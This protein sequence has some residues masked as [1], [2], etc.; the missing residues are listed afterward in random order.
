MGTGCATL[1]GMKRWSTVALVFGL[2]VVVPA[3][4]RARDG[5]GAVAARMRNVVFHLDNGVELRVAD[6]SGHLVSR[7]KNKPP[8]FDDVK[9]YTL[10]IDS[11]RVS[12]TPESLMNVMNNVVFAAPDAP[13]KNLKIAVEGN[14]LVQTG[15]LRKGV[16]IPFS[17][18]AT[19]AATPDGRI[20]MHPSTIKA[21]G[22]V[23]KGVLD[24]LGL[25]LDR[26]VKTKGSS[27][28][29]VEGDDLLL[30]PQ[31][32]LPPPAIR[33]HVTKVWIENGVVVEQFCPENAK[34]EL[35]PPDPHAK[36]YMYYR[37]ATL[38]FGKLTMEDTDLLLEDADQKDPFDFS[39]AKY[40]EQLVAGYSKNTPAHGLIVY[41]PD[42]SAVESARS[43]SARR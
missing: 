34:P 3:S 24:F 21:V 1:D 43:R 30:D 6:L 14:E 25:H 33:G 37:Y 10:E 39:P 5:E 35:T 18:R 9:S 12:M 16:G 31:T 29:K 22:F 7:V 27:P 23:S 4:T 42:L 13:I 32:L 41:M 11:A 36:N 28:V 15:T 17:M 2:V 20:R 26:L 38:R 8:V 19:L 40:E